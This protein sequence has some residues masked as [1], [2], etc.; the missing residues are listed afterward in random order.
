MR[1]IRS[2]LQGYPFV[3]LLT[4]LFCST[5]PAF[6][7]QAPALEPP[8][9]DFSAGLEDAHT[10]SQF[11]I[12]AATTEWTFHKTTDGQHPD[13]I[14]QARLWLI[15]RARQEPATE[16]VWLATSTEA[17][18]ADGRAF[19]GVDLTLLQ[20]EFAALD[21]KP[22]AAFD[23]RLYNAA[24]AHSEDLIARD[25]QDHTGQFDLVDTSG[26]Q[27]TRARGNVF[28]FAD[29]A[30]NAH[31]A[32][33]IDWGGSDGT[34]MQT[35]R[36]HRQAIMAIDG[37]YSNVGIAAIADNDPSTSVGPLVM[38]GNYAVADTSA[39][40]HY[41]R[42]VVGT[43]WQDLNANDRYDPGEGFTGVIVT[44]DQ[45]TF[46]AVTS[47]G[48]GYAIPITAPGDYTLTFSGGGIGA[49]VTK[50]VTVGTVSALLDYEIGALPLAGDVNEDGRLSIDDAR[51]ALQYFVGT[52]TLTSS[53]QS[54][55]DINQNGSITPSDALCIFQ[56]VLGVPSC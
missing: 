16:G 53:Q 51:W 20:S 55:A 44:P 29:S 45:G 27:Y 13:G 18:I 41:N 43:V 46:F 19:F 3:C 7:Q 24:R 35:G 10:T 22:P 28:S 49:D 38:T 8:V 6:A 56:R 26:F 5:S 30:L 4:T 17:D 48:G 37:T 25:A 40:N 36:G 23:V 9:R 31:A 52:R 15:N 50:S 39:A 34:G 12:S 2:C 1:N 11:H 32:F 21:A 33:N 47:V 54:R 42:F 14:E